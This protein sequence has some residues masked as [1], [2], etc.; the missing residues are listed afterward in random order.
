M[1]ANT[2]AHSLAGLRS[3]AS[4]GREA[5]AYF[6][7]CSCGVVQPEI[8]GPLAAMGAPIAAARRAGTASACGSPRHCE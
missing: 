6:E 1:L 8:K 7:K 3:A 5:M 2:T 4:L